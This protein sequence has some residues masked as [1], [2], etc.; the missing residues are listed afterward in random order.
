MKRPSPLT[1]L[2]ALDFSLTSLAREGAYVTFYFCI[3]EGLWPILRYQIDN[4]SV[5]RAKIGSTARSDM[6]SFLLLGGFNKKG[7]RLGNIL[8]KG[9]TRSVI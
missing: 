3:L 8:K 7:Y 4:F 1:C 6:A 2:V 5:R 9:N